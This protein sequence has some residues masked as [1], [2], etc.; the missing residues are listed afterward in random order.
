MKSPFPR[1]PNLHLCRVIFLWILLVPINRTSEWIARR[2][3]LQVPSFM[4][5][6]GKMKSHDGIVFRLFVWLAAGCDTAKKM[7]ET[8]SWTYH[9][10]NWL[11]SW[12]ETWTVC[13][14]KSGNFPFLFIFF[15]ELW[16]RWNKSTKRLPGRSTE[17]RP[18]SSLRFGSRASFFN[19]HAKFFAV[20][21]HH[22]VRNAFRRPHLRCH[23]GGM[24]RLP[25]TRAFPPPLPLPDV[26]QHPKWIHLQNYSTPFNQ[27]VCL[28]G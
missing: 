14:A 1:E 9:P 21:L 5:D 25:L 23:A 13:G 15:I 26:Y 16:Q 28:H 18:C 24:N 20:S 11:L 27:P 2:G 17:G 6:W 7:E 22:P 10:G 4:E 19:P 12:G 8:S 3:S